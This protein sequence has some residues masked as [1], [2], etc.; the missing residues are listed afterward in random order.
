M[1]KSPEEALYLIRT[2]KLVQ[3]VEADQQVFV[4][5][6]QYFPPWGLARISHRTRDFPNMLEYLY[7]PQ[8]GEGVTVYVADTG[9]RIS[10]SEFE[11]RASWGKTIP[12]GEPDQ[13]NNGHGTHV[14]GTIAG[15]TYGVA[16]KARIV[17][18]KVLSGKGS[19][20]NSDVIAGLAFIWQHYKENR[21][22]KGAVV[23]LSLS[24]W[25]STAMN[26]AVEALIDAG[27]F[28]VAAAGN[29]NMDACQFSPGNSPKVITV[30]ASDRNDVR[31][32]FSN[33]GPCVTLFAPG[34]EVKSAHNQSDED[35][36]ILSGT[37]MATPHVVGVI[38]LLLGRERGGIDPDSMKW[39]LLNIATNNTVKDVK[40]TTNALLWSDPPPT[41]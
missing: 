38:A 12:Q 6:R 19:G 34:K 20:A 36:T 31:A 24:S 8:A 17:A 14:A 40:N 2:S 33:W 30:A 16:K 26:T 29:S 7:Y 41:S 37:S 21:P 4:M 13:D 25:A 10:H 3:Y 23:N 1:T 15:Q 9:V 39:W 18:V 27:I 35:T 28:V 5:E 11:K 22:E 32:S